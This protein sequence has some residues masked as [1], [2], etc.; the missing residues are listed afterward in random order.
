LLAFSPVFPGAQ[1]PASSVLAHGKGAYRETL[2]YGF[3]VFHGSHFEG[4][5]GAK[6]RRSCGISDIVAFAARIHRQFLA[7]FFHVDGTY[8]GSGEPKVVPDT[9]RK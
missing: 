9:E 6:P 7:N 4:L 5:R 3:Q 2:D 1:Q 8:G